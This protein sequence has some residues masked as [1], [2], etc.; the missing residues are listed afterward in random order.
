M[1]FDEI[2]LIKR[3]G[4]IFKRWFIRLRIEIVH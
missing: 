3:R 4:Y 1:K 2:K